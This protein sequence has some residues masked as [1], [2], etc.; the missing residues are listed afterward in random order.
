[1]PSVSVPNATMGGAKS[2]TARR[3]PPVAWPILLRGCDMH[4]S[5]T[6]LLGPNP[7]GLC[8]CGCGER[9]S[10]AP[11]TT[12]ARG[13]VKGQPMRYIHGHN[14]RR[15]PVEYIEE[16]HGY[17]TPCWVWQRAVLHGYGYLGGGSGDN[18]RR[19]HI[20]YWERANGPVP[21]GLQLDHLCR[22][23]SCVRPSHLEA[24][25][26][27]EN[28][29]RGANAKLRESDIAEIRALLPTASPNDIAR[30]YGVTACTIRD[31]AAGRRWRNA[32]IGGGTS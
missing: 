23:R 14:A 31:I 7:S 28:T 22:V 5:S 10:I 8:M 21:D 17:L 1:M 27:T 3:E 13:R 26:S 19:A 9:T 6:T 20:V 30:A 29:R 12:T 15:S 2:A 25:T 18:H 24:V 11:H 16:D 32:A 4:D